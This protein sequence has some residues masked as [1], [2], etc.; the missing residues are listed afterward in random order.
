MQIDPNYARA[1]AGLAGVYTVTKER[2]PPE[3]LPEWGTAVERALQ[4]GPNIAESH[5]RAAQYYWRLGQPEISEAHCKRA[6]ALNPSDPLV[7]SVSAGR[8]FE[9]G[10]WSEGIAL[11]RRAVAVDPLAAVGRGNL[12]N[13]LA[14]IGEWERGDQRARES[15]RVEPDT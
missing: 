6:I 9:A 1:W 12:G 5:V 13:Y 8:E 2:A 4:L 15:A 10:H 7:L 3:P 14:A 11:Q